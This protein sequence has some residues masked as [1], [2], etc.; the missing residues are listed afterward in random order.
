MTHGTPTPATVT[1]GC[2]SAKIASYFTFV[3]ELDSLMEKTLLRRQWPCEML[4]FVVNISH[5]A[6]TDALDVLACLLSRLVG[7]QPWTGE[8]CFPLRSRILPT[9]PM[10]HFGCHANN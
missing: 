5:T 2:S 9:V 8:R 3:A 1:S 10:I 6:D 4:G 7:R